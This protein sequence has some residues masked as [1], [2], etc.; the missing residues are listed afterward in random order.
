MSPK[1]LVQAR[2]PTWP[3][4]HAQARNR[5]ELPARSR[6]ELFPRELCQ[7]RQW[8]Q[9]ASILSRAAYARLPRNLLVAPIQAEALAWDQLEATASSNL[10]LVV[11]PNREANNLRDLRAA[12]A[13]ES[14]ML[15]GSNSR[16]AG[17]LKLSREVNPVADLSLTNRLRS[18]SMA[19]RSGTER[20]WLSTDASQ[21]QHL[22]P[23]QDPLQVTVQESVQK[24][25]THEF[26]EWPWSK[27]SSMVRNHQQNLL[28]DAKK[29][30]TSSSL[31]KTATARTPTMR[32]TFPRDSSSAMS[33]CLNDWASL[34]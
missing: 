24:S 9:L 21:D 10:L 31:R 3:R 27:R 2:N 8:G 1:S 32:V 23:L 25:R 20:S 5:L 28:P 26:R 4:N 13:S 14:L 16:L 19:R 6:A 11:D 34:P 22:D 30:A 29:G 17:Q 12:K 15:T 7:R 18:Q 33:D